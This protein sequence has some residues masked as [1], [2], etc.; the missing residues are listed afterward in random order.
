VVL[1]LGR[2]TLAAKGDAA[3]YKLLFPTVSANAASL[4]PVYRGRYGWWFYE[5]GEYDSA[6][7]WL[8]GAVQ[9]LPADPALQTLLGWALIEQHNLE[10]AMQRFESNANQYPAYEY[11]SPIQRR[12]MFNERRVGLAVAKWQAQQHESALSEFNGTIYSQP[13]WLNPKWV[14]ALYSPGVAKTIEEMKAE[15]KKRYGHRTVKID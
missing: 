10:G 2:L 13:E 11:G 1:E 15:Q 6:A 4:P 12:R 3:T 14:E 7:K 9:E 5:V 8:Q